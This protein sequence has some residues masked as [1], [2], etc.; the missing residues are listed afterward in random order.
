MLYSVI[1]AQQACSTEIG[2][3][4]ILVFTNGYLLLTAET[5][6]DI[7]NEKLQEQELAAE[8]REWQRKLKSQHKMM[9]GVH[10]SSQHT[11]QVLKNVHKLENQLQLVRTSYKWKDLATTRKGRVGW[12]LESILFPGGP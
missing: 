3:L 2:Y 11:S 8:I 6:Q 12:I 1:T 4:P 7:A 9:G 10:M 5:E